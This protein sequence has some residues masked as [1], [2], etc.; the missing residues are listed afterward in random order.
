VTHFSHNLTVSSVL[1]SSS[2]NI[3]PVLDLEVMQDVNKK[4]FKEF[5]ATKSAL[6]NEL[7]SVVTTFLL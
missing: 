1:V 6:A 3:P 2:G 5:Y 7:C 4:L